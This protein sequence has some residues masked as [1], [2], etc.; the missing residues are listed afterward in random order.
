ML[1][2]SGA[3][4]LHWAT[5]LL[6]SRPCSARVQARRRPI[7]LAKRFAER[8]RPEVQLGE[9]VLARLRFKLRFL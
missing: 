1:L 8:E 3:V 4:R 6:A 5:S 2:F 9:H 7:Q